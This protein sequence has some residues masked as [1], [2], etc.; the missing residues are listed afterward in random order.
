MPVPIEGAPKTERVVDWGK[1]RI[2]G[3][4]EKQTHPRQWCPCV[5]RRLMIIPESG[6]E[7]ETER[8][9]I[10]S[11][12]SRRPNWRCRPAFRSSVHGSI[13]LPKICFSK[14]E[15][16]HIGKFLSVDSNTGTATITSTATHLKLCAALIQA[17]YLKLQEQTYFLLPRVPTECV[18]TF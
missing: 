11:P 15:I 16:K 14:I 18:W 6:R 9:A 1:A 5:S 17:L 12:E 10:R 2:Y 3:P 4:L 7:R 8:E 13:Y